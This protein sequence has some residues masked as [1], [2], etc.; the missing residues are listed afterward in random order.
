MTQPSC[1]LSVKYEKPFKVIAQ[2]GP[3]LYTLKLPDS[4]HSVYPVFHI[5]ML[6]PATPNAIPG[7]TQPLPP[8]IE[9]DEEE[10]YEIS[11]ILNFKIDCWRKYKLQYLVH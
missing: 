6:E 11:E 10:K 1:K 8:L 4:L 7:C 5:F 3:Q 2:P 9:I